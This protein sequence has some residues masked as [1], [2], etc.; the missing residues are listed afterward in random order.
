MLLPTPKAAVFQTS[1][2]ATLLLILLY[3]SK[4]NLVNGRAT[5]QYDLHTKFNLYGRRLYRPSQMRAT[6]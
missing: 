1:V 2:D 3:P 6:R 5:Q 4:V